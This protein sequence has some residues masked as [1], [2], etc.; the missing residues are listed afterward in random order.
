VLIRFLYA[1]AAGDLLNK[2]VVSLNKSNADFG[3]FECVFLSTPDVWLSDCDGL[4]LLVLVL[5]CASITIPLLFKVSIEDINITPKIAIRTMILNSLFET[6][7]LILFLFS[8]SCN[9]IKL[10]KC[11]VLYISKVFKSN[12]MKTMNQDLIIL[13]QMR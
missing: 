6:R 9:N 5:L 10:Y 7:V 13:L 12:I 1:A 8:L 11:I 3:N 2:S 4:V